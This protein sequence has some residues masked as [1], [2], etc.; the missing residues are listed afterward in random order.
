MA[1]AART[2]SGNWAGSLG[3]LDVAPGGV[4]SPALSRGIGQARSQSHVGV[5]SGG[6]VFFPGKP[7]TG[8]PPRE[9]RSAD[10]ASDSPL[11]ERLFTVHYAC[12]AARG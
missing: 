4:H 8:G 2:R 3:N 10:E 5:A 1:R 11:A 12:L 7:V 6:A 9:Y